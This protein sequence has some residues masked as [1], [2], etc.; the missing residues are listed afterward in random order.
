M[1]L[2][3]RFQAHKITKTTFLLTIIGK[4][5]SCALKSFKNE[6]IMHINNLGIA[7]DYNFRLKYSTNQHKFNR[8]IQN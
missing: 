7:N 3:S 5:L 6:E 8:T 2:I 4:D 1:I